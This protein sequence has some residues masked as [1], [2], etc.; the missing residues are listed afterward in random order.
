MTISNTSEN[1]SIDFSKTGDLATIVS[2]LATKDNWDEECMSRYSPMDYVDGTEHVI[3][4]ID[5]M[6]ELK[7][8][9]EE[10]KKQLTGLVTERF[11]FIKD[12]TERYTAD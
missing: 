8:T 4:I 11:D 6:L 10:M 1:E 3:K 5:R 7:L 2:G 9:F 12:A